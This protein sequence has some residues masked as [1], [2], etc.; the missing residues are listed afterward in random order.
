MHSQDDIIGPLISCN[1]LEK[2]LKL[3][4]LTC[5]IP[6]PTGQS[7]TTHEQLVC[8]RGR[9]PVKQYISSKPGKYG[10]KPQTICDSTCFYIWKMQVYIRKNAGSARETNQGT[11]IVLDLAE[12]IDNSCRNITCDNFFTNLSLVQKLLQKNLTLI[13]TMRKNKPEFPT[14]FT[15]AKGRNVKSTVFGFQ[16]DAMIAS[17]CPKTNRAVNMLSTMHS[18]PEIESTSDQKPSIILFHNKTK[19]S[20]DTLHKMVR[21]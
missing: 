11:R 3:G 5:V 15:V 7:M 1:Q 6:K 20:V 17:H 8:F 13:G 21:S 9:C 12:G 10:I 2:C 18:Q 14:E 19:S 4:T 16:L